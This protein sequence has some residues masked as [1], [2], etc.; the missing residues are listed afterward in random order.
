MKRCCECKKLV[1]P[2]QQSVISA[3]PIHLKCHQRVIL[4]KARQDPEVG[5]L[6]QQEILEFEIATGSPTHL[7]I[8]ALQTRYGN[9]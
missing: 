9:E 3:C 7:R 2:W 5:K 8:D 6:M 4:E 1:W